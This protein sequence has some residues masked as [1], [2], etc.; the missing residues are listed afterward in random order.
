[1][2]AKYPYFI[3]PALL[4]LKREGQKIERD[5]RDKLLNLVSLMASDRSVLADI[6]GDDAG[7]FDSFYPEEEPAPEP[8][9]NS[10]IDV[11][12]NRYA[13]SV[14][15]LLGYTFKRRRSS[16]V[17]CHLFGKYRKFGPA[18]DSPID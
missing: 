6:V 17:T 10:T 4:Y 15:R 2:H 8:T 3:T 11:F 18:N 5:E 7:R 12:L 16:G 13:Q 9:T 14:Y 1:M